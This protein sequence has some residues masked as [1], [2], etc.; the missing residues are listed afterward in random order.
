LSLVL[1]FVSKIIAVFIR[2]KIAKNFG[3]K[4]TVGVSK[5]GVLIGDVVFYCM[6]FISI[7]IA[8]TIAGINIGLL[9]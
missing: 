9:M 8:F 3:L 1:I 2:N 4:Q 7:Y 6:S 5:M